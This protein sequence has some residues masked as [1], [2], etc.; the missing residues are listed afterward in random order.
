MKGIVDQSMIEI[1]ER[2]NLLHR[3]SYVHKIIELEDDLGIIV[4]DIL[5][6]PIRTNKNFR[7]YLLEIRERL[8]VYKRRQLSQNKVEEYIKGFYSGIEDILEYY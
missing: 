1:R 7:T 4:E 3:E 6:V 2:L 8:G 5:G